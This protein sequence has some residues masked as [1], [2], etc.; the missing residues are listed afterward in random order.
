MTH[1]ILVRAQFAGLSKAECFA[2]LSH[3]VEFLRLPSVRCVLLKAGSADPNGLGAVRCVRALGL[4]LTEEIVDFAAPQYYS[5]RIRSIDWLGVPLPIRH[6]I[7]SI[8]LRQRGRSVE[9]TW[10]SE[11]SAPSAWLEHKLGR[12]FAALFRKLLARALG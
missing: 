10:E 8:S 12:V 4:N 5:Y 6:R 11:F 3:H 7:G 1:H 9:V 2:K